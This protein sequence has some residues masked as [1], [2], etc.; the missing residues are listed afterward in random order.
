MHF[1]RSFTNREAPSSRIWRVMLPSS[2][3]E[4]NTQIFTI[5]VDAT[6][7]WKLRPDDEVVLREHNTSR[8]V[9]PKTAK[10]LQI[11]TKSGHES[12]DED[13]GDDRAE[14]GTLGQDRP[15]RS[16]H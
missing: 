2:L 10:V 15:R 5:R 12:S 8:D 9:A 14:E 13:L 4:C 16:G 3:D 1:C 11:A 6:E 7:D